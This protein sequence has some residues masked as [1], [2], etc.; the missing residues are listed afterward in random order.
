MP[1]RNALIRSRLD[2]VPTADDFPYTLT[3]GPSLT[4]SQLLDNLSIGMG[5]GATNQLKGTW[6]M[7]AHPINAIKGIGSLAKQAVTQPNKLAAAL[8]AYGK[9]GVTSGPM[10]FGR[11]VGENISL[12]RPGTV[13]TPG[14]FMSKEL[15]PE[16]LAEVQS[17]AEDV[18]NLANDHGRVFI[19]WSPSSARDLAGMN[20]SRDFVSG[21]VHGGLSAIE[22]LAGSHPVDVA[23][24][25]ATYGFLRM[26]D[27]RSLPRVYAGTRIGTDSDSH[28]L[29]KTS[30]LLRDTPASVVRAL[31][32]RA[33]VVL[34]LQGD[35]ARD[36]ARLSRI[37]DTVGKEIVQRDIDAARAKLA[38]LLSGRK[39]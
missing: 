12:R 1:N 22:I 33:D 11:F 27:S 26:Q 8:M 5:Y 18:A 32:Q 19:R 35:I 6:D 9:Q 13:K 38:E 10:E 30:Q 31:D 37:T 21:A 3:S 17:F 7:V 2:T 23:K 39:P 36:T 20:P 34:A 25:L 15:T 4:T 24:A 14:K 16:S 29:I 28:A